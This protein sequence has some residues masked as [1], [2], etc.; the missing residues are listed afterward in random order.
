[1]FEPTTSSPPVKRATKL[2]H[3]P[4]PYSLVG[5]EN[6]LIPIGG[7]VTKPHTVTFEK[8]VSSQ[9]DTEET[10]LAQ[11]LSG[12]SVTFPFRDCYEGAPGGYAWY[13]D[14]LEESTWQIWITQCLCGI[15]AT[16]SGS[17]RRKTMLW[18]GWVSPISPRRRWATSSMSICLPCVI[19]SPP[20]NPVV[21]SRARRASPISSH[22]SPG[23]S[24]RSTTRLTT[25][26]KP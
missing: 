25:H 4:S 15:R 18:S 9:V 11:A 5:N 7:Q 17:R 2:R 3:S 21:K 13:T 8:Q 22:P 14:K 26:P 12:D 10:G 19:R 1:G 23:P 20:A 6:Q 24:P 16:T